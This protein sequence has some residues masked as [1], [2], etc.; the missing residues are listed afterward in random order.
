MLAG[1]PIN[2]VQLIN[3]PVSSVVK[4]NAFGAEGLGF[5]SLAGLIG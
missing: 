3:Q 2:Y 5:D 1:H 4:H